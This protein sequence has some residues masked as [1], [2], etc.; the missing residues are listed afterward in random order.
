MIL[1]G[2]SGLRVG[3]TWT[4]GM[5]QSGGLLFYSAIVSV[6]EFMGVVLGKELRVYVPD[7]YEQ[8][9]VLVLLSIIGIRLT[10]KGL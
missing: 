3:L 2:I 5:Y 7:E 1:V 6:P 10:S 9:G 4:L 8:A